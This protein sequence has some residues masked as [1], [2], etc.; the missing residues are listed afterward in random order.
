MKSGYQWTKLVS[1]SL[2]TVGFA[3]VEQA[4]LPEITVL[5]ER[6][7]LIS[8]GDALV[9]ATKISGSRARVPRGYEL[10]Q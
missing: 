7:D 4:A 10:Q 5:S 9:E 6:A 3:C 8:G 2:L 1:G